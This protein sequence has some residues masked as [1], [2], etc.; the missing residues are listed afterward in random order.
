MTPSTVLCLSLLLVGLSSLSCTRPDP[1][2]ARV[3]AHDGAALARWRSQG[4]ARFTGFDWR[5]FDDA[6]QEIRLGVMLG[7]H[8]SGREPVES[9]LCG[10]VHGLTVREVLVLGHTAAFQ[11]LER[12][13]ADLQN[14]ADAN[15]W[16]VTKPG[17]AASANHLSAFRA[18]QQQR[19]EH[20]KAG[21]ENARRRIAALGGSLEPS[22]PPP[23][24]V[25][26]Q[27]L[28]REAARDE[29]QRMIHKLRAVGLLRFGAW[30]IRFDPEGA[31]LPAELRAEYARQSAAARTAGRSITAVR[32][33]GRWWI[34][35][36]ACAPPD[37]P[38]F[39][40]ANLTAADRAEIGRDWVHLQAEL[41]TREAAAG[42]VAEMEP[43]AEVAAENVVRPSPA[44]I[45]QL[46]QSAALKELADRQRILTETNQLLSATQAED[47]PP[48][49]VSR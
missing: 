31:R 7:G 16:L 29:V 18:R 44:R 48:S 41:W 26:A 21:I 4:A 30:P 3:A 2:T 8:A 22:A 36:A 33:R 43:L 45:L 23:V 12:E 10:Q 42:G 32:H 6:L 49:Q 38:P 19:L 20:A 17:D 14:F 11:R 47:R 40:T 9:S 46:S 5:E 1:L 39:V 25:T 15:A 27:P 13:C 35:D 37:F 24:S 28:A 34:Y